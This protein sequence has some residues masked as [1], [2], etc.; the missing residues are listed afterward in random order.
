VPQPHQ[1]IQIRRRQRQTRFWRKVG[2]CIPM[3][4]NG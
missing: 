2:Q 1:F 3:L 4:K